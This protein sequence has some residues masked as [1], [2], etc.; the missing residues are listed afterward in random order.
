MTKIIPFC[1][2]A[3]VAILANEVSLPI[4]YKSKKMEI[5]IIGTSTL[6]QIQEAFKA[7]YPY[8]KLAF[9][10]TTEGASPIFNKSHLITDQTLTLQS[11]GKASAHGSFSING[12]LKVSTLE[13][14]FMEQFGIPV[15]VFRKSGSAWLQTN[16]SDNE[17]L[18][19]QNEKGQLASSAN[20]EH[21]ETDFELYHEQV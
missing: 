15:Q 4:T 21:G 13:Q 11:L 1:R 17:T 19:E 2:L 6:S 12:H 20:N 9:F 8:L 14:H 7:H 18:T 3:A 16:T 10:K 5:N